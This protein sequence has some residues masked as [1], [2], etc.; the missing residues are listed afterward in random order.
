MERIAIHIMGEIVLSDDIGK[1]MKKWREMFGIPQIE[2][3]R[4]LDVSPSVISDYEVGRRKNPGV[5]IVKKYVY[6][7]LE[8]DKERGGHTIK[9][10]NKVLNPTSMKAILQIKEYQNP[11]GIKDLISI[12]DGKI[13]CGENNTNYQIFGHTVV[14]SV[15]AILEMNGQDF[16]NLYGWTTERALVF[17]EVSA[18]R[19]PMVAIR[20]SNIKPRVVIFNGVSE[21]DKLAVKLAEIEGIMLVVTELTTDELLK[22]LKEIR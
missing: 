3:A 13:V 22:R 17:T 2:T 18:G 10:L 4:Y 16:L 1:A 5:N 12:I 7:L 11:T 9:A 6:A 15:K 21:L 20:V 14:D 19:S 8:I